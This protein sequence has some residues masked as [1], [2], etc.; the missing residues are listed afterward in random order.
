L[1]GSVA[2][3]SLDRAIESVTATSG[4]AH[5]WEGRELVIGE[6]R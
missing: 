6:A 4:L 5:R 2:G 3:I 1:R